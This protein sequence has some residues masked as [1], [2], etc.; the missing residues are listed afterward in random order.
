MGRLIGKIKWFSRGRNAGTLTT[1]GGISLDFSSTD[2]DA[3]TRFTEG[4]LVT[5]EPREHGTTPPYADDVRAQ[6]E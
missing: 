5:Y 1:I 3:P 4:Q 6:P 2:A